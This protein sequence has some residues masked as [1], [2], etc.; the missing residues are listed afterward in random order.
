MID[1]LDQPQ[2]CT[3]IVQEFDKPIRKLDETYPNLRAALEG[4]RIY[5]QTNNPN[6]HGAWVKDEYG[7]IIRSW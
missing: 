1:Q 2:P 6:L 3:I 7:N 5:M 4:Y